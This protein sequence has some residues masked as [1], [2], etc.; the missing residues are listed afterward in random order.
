MQISI[1]GKLGSGKSTVCKMIRDRY[2]YE[3]FSPA[4]SSAKLHVRWASARWS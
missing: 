2:D 4:P 3:I 1:T